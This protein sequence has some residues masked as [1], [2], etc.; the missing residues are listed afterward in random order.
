MLSTCL[1]PVNT[2][3]A[4]I[5][6]TSDK[7]ECRV[8]SSALKGDVG[9]GQPVSLWEPHQPQGMMHVRWSRA[10]ALFY[11]RVVGFIAVFSSLPRSACS[12]SGRTCCERCFMYNSFLGLCLLLRNGGRKTFRVLLAPEMAPY[13]FISTRRGDG[14]GGSGRVKQNALKSIDEESSSSIA[15][16]SCHVIL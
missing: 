11:V 14:E 15:L 9:A 4:K 5:S 8:W 13:P 2:R 6:S 1:Q 12:A 10:A 7:L 16:L 3:T